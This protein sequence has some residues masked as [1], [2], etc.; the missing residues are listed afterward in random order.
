M[1]SVKDILSAL[2]KRE[3][4]LVNATGIRHTKLKRILPCESLSSSHLSLLGGRDIKEVIE[5][6]EESNTI[7]TRIKLD[8]KDLDIVIEE[9]LLNHLE[10]SNWHQFGLHLGLYDQ[11][12][13]SIKKDHGE[14]KQCLIQCMSAWLREKDKVREKGGPSWSS[15]ARALDT[16]GEKSIASYIKTKY[17]T[18]I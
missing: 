17:C 12:L 1:Y 9:L 15:L 8:I 4:F 13:N 3:D 16:V 7:I 2:Y 11:T 6:A 14:C 10:Y 18:K 5:I